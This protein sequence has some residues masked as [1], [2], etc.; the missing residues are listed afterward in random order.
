MRL[1]PVGTPVPHD[2]RCVTAIKVIHAMQTAHDQK[3]ST[4]PVLVSFFRSLPKQFRCRTLRNLVSVEPLCFSYVG[5]TSSCSSHCPFQTAPILG[6][7]GPRGSVRKAHGDG[8]V[9]C[10]FMASFETKIIPII[11]HHTPHSLQT[12]YSLYF[13]CISS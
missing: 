13:L 6:Y 10:H 5:H 12:S 2:V 11:S 1:L 8:T 3:G 7:V 9:V 4:L